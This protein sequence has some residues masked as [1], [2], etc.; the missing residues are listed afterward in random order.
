M[1]RSDD[2]TNMDTLYWAT[3]IVGG[4][5]VLAAIFGGGETDSDVE[6]EVDVDADADVDMDADGGVGW[7]DL[8]SLRTIFL[9]AAFFGLSG[10]LLSLTGIS[11]LARGLISLFTGLGVGLVGNLVIK[12]IGYEHVS[13]TLTSGDLA[14][15]T[16]KVLI[17]F[18]SDD[19][20]KVE[21]ISRGRRVQ[22]RACAYENVEENFA[23]GDE[24][25]VMHVKDAVAQVLK[26]N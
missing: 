6:A 15:N 3:L 11:E 22:L 16:A 4:V 1:T 18:G 2:R 26:P 20:G 7:V 13:S 19:L 25:V 14:G 23:T 9:F 21:L 24:V 17:P 5:F 10:V 8:F 12:R